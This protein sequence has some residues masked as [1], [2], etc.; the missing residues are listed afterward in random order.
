MKYHDKSSCIL[1]EATTCI[2]ARFCGRLPAIGVSVFSD[3]TVISLAD[4]HGVRY[5]K[6]CIGRL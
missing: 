6:G 4:A 2:N 1:I 3:V 5:I